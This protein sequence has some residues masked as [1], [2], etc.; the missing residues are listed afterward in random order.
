MIK[1]FLVFFMFC[2]LFFG[3]IGCGKKSSL[4]PPNLSSLESQN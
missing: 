1:K 4:I 2:L 3:V